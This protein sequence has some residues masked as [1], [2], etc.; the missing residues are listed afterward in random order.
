M[1]KMDNEISG[2]FLECSCRKLVDMTGHM[3]MCL[4]RLT[5]AQIWE[6]HGA[7]E[8]AVGNLVL[9]LCGNMRQWVIAGVG[10]AVDVRD[11]DAEFSTDG[12]IDAG[13]LIGRF[14]ETVAEAREVIVSLPGERL[15]ERINPQHG[16]VSVLEAIYHVVGHVQQH[17]GQI[18]LVTKQMIEQ[19]LDLT[20]PRPR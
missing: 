14:A 17:V 16:E 11:R 15:T 7:H 12:G 19:D 4:S 1:N 3:E 6:R 8:N 9:H 20:M 5:R 10:G 13:E 18:I 2:L